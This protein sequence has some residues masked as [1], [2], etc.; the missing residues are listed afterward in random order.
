MVTTNSDDLAET[1]RM[2][3]QHG[4]RRRYYHDEI[5]WNTRLDGFQGAILESQAE[6]H[7]AAGTNRRRTI[8]ERYHAL[9][10]ANGVGRIRN[11]SSR[12][13]LCFPH[14]VA[15]AHHVWH[16]Y[17]IRCARRDALREFLS[18]AQDRLG[19]L[20]SRPAAH[21]GGSQRPWLRRRQTFRRPNAPPAK[22]WRCP[23]SPN[24]ATTNSKPS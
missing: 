12:M 15:G 17:V 21:A 5:G 16:Q 22:C 19:D 9:F 11:L 2:L 14:E 24:Y 23:S 18:S 13:A 4:M 8:A 10:R 20:L 3:R 1:A 6:V 7:R